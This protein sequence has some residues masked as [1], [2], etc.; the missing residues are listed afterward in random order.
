MSSRSTR[1]A[2]TLV[3]LLVVVAIIALLVSVLLPALS[4]AR[5]TARVSVCGSNLRQIGL[6]FHTYAASEHD[7]LPASI[8]RW[9]RPIFDGEP[10]WVH[11]LVDG[12]YLPRGKGAT[13]GNQWIERVRR[14]P[15]L[16]CPSQASVNNHEGVLWSYNPRWHFLGQSR[17]QSGANRMTRKNEVN[18]PMRMVLITETAGGSP[19]WTPYW[20]DPKGRS[21]AREAGWQP[22]HLEFTQQTFLILDGH[23]E[24][25][26]YKGTMG[27][28]DRP[29][30][31]SHTW[32]YGEKFGKDGWMLERKDA[33]LSS[34]W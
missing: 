33:G 2:F 14:V 17:Q 34:K 13:S 18:H 31:D 29:I 16:M 20:I 22:K 4:K 26:H 24:V 12:E 32:A 23:V 11:S 6:A 30:Q 19:A 8:T 28:N 27:A 1:R 15:G 21:Y 10:V 5:D 3:E 25:M 9:A 7:W